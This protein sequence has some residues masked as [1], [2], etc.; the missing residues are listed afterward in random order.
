[1]SIVPRGLPRLGKWLSS[2]GSFRRAVIVTDSRVDALYGAAAAR[3]LRRFDPVR[4]V[5]PPGER[6]KRAVELV[7]VWER[8]ARLGIERGDVIV[9]LGGGAVG[10]LA[11]F[12]AASWLRGVAWVVV[13]TTVVAQ[14]DSS[15]GGKTGINLAA[16]KNLAGAFHQPLGVFGDPSL[17]ATLSD[18]DFRA[19][20]AEVVKAGVIADAA[21]FRMLERDAE[22][23]LRREAGPLAVVIERAARAKARIVQLDETE[24]GPRTALNFGHTL[25]HAVE[26]ASGYRARHGEAVAI[27]MR[28]ATRLAVRTGGL[29]ARD[30]LRIETLLDRLSLPKRITGYSIRRLEAAMASDKKR[31]NSRVRW[32]LTPR[33]GRASVPRLI[34]ARLVRAVLHE[35]G[36][37]A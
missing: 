26:A 7:R 35:A 13:P 6:A 34:P 8:L 24:A 17:L 14:V 15:I 23:I 27:G 10:D 20:L 28:V 4:V 29:P 31:R 1:L 3:A 18:R 9:A 12:A 36:A 19:G 33:I 16:G 30:G 22:R 37:R 21:L 32:V 5:C 2:L 11:G 25:G